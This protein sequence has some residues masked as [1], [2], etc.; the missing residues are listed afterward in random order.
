[1][2]IENSVAIVGMAGRFPGARD[3]TQYWKNLAAG[4]GS[5]ISSRDTD[6]A[7]AHDQT[8]RS[9][10][11]HS[12][13]VI[14]DVELFDADF[15]SVPPAEASW[16][17]PQH[18]IFLECAW[19]ALED[20]GCDPSSLSGSVSVYAGTNSN[21]YVL[22]RLD[23]LFG[24]DRARFMQILIGNEKDFLA[25]RVSYKLD[26]RGESVT[27]QTS[28]STSLVAV[29]LACQSLLS[30]QSDRALAGGVSIRIPQ[31]AGYTYEA[32]MIASPDG[33]CRPFDARAAGTVPGN[34]VGVVVLRRLAD[35]IADRDHCYA[36]IRGS[37]INNDGR[38]KVGFTAPAVEGQADVISRALAM[39]GVP[40]ESIRYIETHGTGTPIGDPIEIE[41]LTRAFRQSTTRRRFCALGAVKANIGHLDTAAGV[42][43]LV[44]ASLAL[45]HQLIPPAAHFERPNPTIDFDNSP[46]YLNT[47]AESWPAGSGPRRAGVSS[48][49]VGGTNVHVVLDEAPGRERSVPARPVQIVTLSAR[50]PTALNEGAG[51]LAQFVD[52]NPRIELRDI[53]Y[54]RNVGRQHF[55]HRRF[56]IA[57][58]HEELAAALRTA[59]HP[60]VD[61]RRGGPSIV[62]MFTGQGAQSLGM[63]RALYEAEPSFREPMDA[64][65]RRADARLDRS[66]SALIY[67]AAEGDRD[68]DATLA[69]PE[70]ALPALFAVEYALAQMWK[71]W[72]VVPGAVIGHSYGELGAA[73]VAG[74]FGVEGLVD[75]AIERGRLMQRMQP[76][77]MLAVPIPE[78]AAAPWLDAGVSVASVNAD[79]RIVLSG[80]T[81][82]MERVERALREQGIKSTWLN[83][84]F[85]YH[86]KLLDPVLDDYAALVERSARAALGLRAVSN[87][88]GE[89]LTDEQAQDPQYWVQQMRQPV[90]FSAGLRHLQAAGHTVFVEIGPGQTLSSL[91]RQVLGRDAIVCAS[92]AR[93]GAGAQADWRTLLESLG[94]LWV[95]GAPVQWQ[96]VERAQEGW[97]VPLPG[98]AFERQRH[99]VESTQETRLAAAPPIETGRP[100]QRAEPPTRAPQRGNGLRVS[101]ESTLVAIWSEVLG[102]PSIDVHDDFF[103]LG[104]DSLT[105]IRILSRLQTA[106][107]VTVT[108]EQ[109]LS[110]PTIVAL[111]ASIEEGMKI[112]GNAADTGSGRPSGLP[113]EKPAGLPSETK[114]DPLSYAQEWLWTLHDLTQGGAAYHL[115]LAVRLRGPISVAGFIDALRG[116]TERQESLRTVFV[117]DGL[118]PAAVVRPSTPIDVPVI[119]VSNCPEALRFTMARR[120]VRAAVARPFDLSHAP[121]WRA[122]LVRFGA[123]DHVA[124]F[125]LHHI[126]SDGWS[127]GILVHDLTAMYFAR[128]MDWP[129]PLPALT[130]QYRQ[131]AERQR[132]SLDRDGGALVAYWKRQLEGVP[133]LLTLSTRPRPARPM[134][135]GGRQTFVINAD[136]VQRLNDLAR[137]AHVTLFMV[138]MSAYQMLLYRLTDQEDFC[139]GAPTAGRL[140]QETEPLIGCFINTL[141]IRADMRG[142]PPFL[143][144]VQR[145]R[146]TTLDAFAHQALPFGRMVQELRPPRAANVTPFFQVIFDFNSTPPPRAPERPGLRV[147]PFGTPMPTAK[148]DL[149]VDV[150]RGSA[151]E[152]LGAAEYDLALFDDRDIERVT[153]SFLA[154]LDSIAANPEG[155]LTSFALESAERREA[156]ERAER[157]R[158]DAR[159]ERLA[160]AKGRRRA[161]VRA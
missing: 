72:G 93:T 103:E 149:I 100:A 96:N 36:V 74:V 62:F 12:G 48:F 10:R 68:A 5:I 117:L 120:A 49:G 134:Y 14:E 13:G 95:A 98:Y 109:V 136:L 60:A 15:F 116:V 104:G 138:L 11:V 87:L 118:R 80:P 54:T 70:F 139:V 51:R 65:L 125:V 44:K 102:R 64:C 84:P 38:G 135:R 145:V 88:T 18:R 113:P 61:R 133:P 42:A 147:E 115:P 40:A 66:L 2:D 82:A 53:A 161:P 52:D 56:A 22:S 28:C 106:L 37:W 81:E 7:D 27:V 156:R 3:V 91:A 9:W 119:D 4:V 76:G 99:W 153:S 16:M 92:L 31:I 85:A 148:T 90:R 67:A 17:D 25:T 24:I 30:G 55:A 151:G 144:L 78:A 121:P 29:H 154:V 141:P 57:A 6:R 59:A 126:I 160:S 79:E 128:M 122:C 112:S 97:L 8:A 131:Y 32:G 132:V 23:Q 105:A 143:E 45:H 107:D 35:A 86:S 137:R 94:R 129:S 140:Q 146:Q 155:R 26:L 108:M 159:R 69:R 73:C 110:S 71:A 83:V 43:G 21:S 130:V 20:A 114:S 89:W 77:R 50:T 150:W 127:M 1:M 101:I 41:A 46:F 152:L 33:H 142:N 75:L 47:S 19:L 34:G 158:D 63:A 123:D 111:A 157:E 39:A 124:L 58:G